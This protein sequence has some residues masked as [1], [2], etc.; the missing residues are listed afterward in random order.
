MQTLTIKAKLEDP[1]QT[2]C[3]NDEEYYFILGQI[4]QFISKVL[5]RNLASSTW[6]RKLELANSS[7][8]QQRIVREFINLNA[9]KI[10]LNNK[11]LARALSMFYGYKTEKRK[12]KENESDYIGGLVAISL[13]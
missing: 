1:E 5:K 2:Y 13:F 9:S 4:S 6:T 10:L 12:T 3:A 7:A 11:P 8:D